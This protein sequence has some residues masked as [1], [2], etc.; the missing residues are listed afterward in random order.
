MGK[1]IIHLTEAEFSQ[2]VLEAT[3]QVIQEYDGFTYGRISN[4]SLVARKDISNGVFSKDVGTSVDPAD[5]TKRT[6]KPLRNV[7]SYER[8]SKA[9]NL[10]KKVRD[11][12]VEHYKDVT[13]M[14]LGTSRTKVDE[15]FEFKLSSIDKIDRD[16]FI[17]SGTITWDNQVFSG[18][19]KYVP[20]KRKCYY[21]NR[22]IGIYNYYL[23]PVPPT[24]D[25]WNNL[26]NFFL[27]SLIQRTR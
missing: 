14:F 9:K 7:N 3:K 24:R 5:P 20:D 2:I 22:R 4:G 6:S 8:L 16:A 11:D 10:D 26:I 18:S 21:T 17:F 19:I 27:D 12:I 23:E 1:R 15:P 25:A 13:F